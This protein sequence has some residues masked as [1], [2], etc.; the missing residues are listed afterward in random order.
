MDLLALT[1]MLVL[2]ILCT[3]YCSMMFAVLLIE[4]LN[5]LLAK[6]SVDWWLNGWLKTF[7]QAAENTS[8]ACLCYVTVHGAPFA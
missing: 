7:A 1:Y 8:N 6:R 4:A 5:C 2:H 3:M